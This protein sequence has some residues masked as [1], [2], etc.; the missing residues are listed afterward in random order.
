MN[1]PLPKEHGSWAM[2]A[3]PLIIGAAVANVWHIPLL[4]LFMAA[5]GFFL[6]R[7]PLAI[8]VKTRKRPSPQRATLWRWAIGYAALAAVSGGALVIIYRLWWLLPMGIFGGALVAFHL[9]LVS[10]REEMTL[11]GELS[12]IAGLAL[13]APMA[14]YTAHGILDETALALWF[15]NALYFGG[16]VFYIKLKVRQQPKSPPPPEL[17]ARLRAAKACLTYHAFALAAAIALAMLALAPPLVPLAFLPVLFK[18][19]YGAWQWQDRKSLSL[20]RLGVVEAI[21]S[22]TFAVVVIIAFR[23][24]PFA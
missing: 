8:L 23:L 5:L 20:V 14:Y 18:V 9:W 7:Y 12:G 4:L 19:W 6:M 15:I 2:F 16:T 3:I 1:M 11:R 13:G 17:T 22:I 10:R 21:F 24:T